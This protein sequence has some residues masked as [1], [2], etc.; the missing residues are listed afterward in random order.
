MNIKRTTTWMALIAAVLPTMALAQFSTGDEVAAKKAWEQFPNLPKSKKVTLSFRNS[1]IDM[2]LDLFM[3][4]SGITIVKDPS[5]KDAITV[6]SP[7][8]VTVADAFN[9]LDTALGLRNFEL[10]KSGNLMVIRPKRQQATID[11]GAGAAGGAGFPTPTPNEV[12]VYRIKY[13]N[14]S[15]VARVVNDVFAPQQG[16]GFGGF[17]NFNFGGGGGGGGL[18]Q[19]GRPQGQGNRGGRTNFGG[20]GGQA[21]RFTGFGGLNFGQQQSNMRASSDDFSNTVIINGPRSQFADIEKLINEIDKQTDA[22]QTSRV[23]KLEFAAAPDLVSVIQNVLTSNAPTGRGGQGNQ[24]VPPQ[25]RFQQAFRTGSFQSA[26][27]TVTADARSNSLVVTG[28]ED[29]HKVVAQVISELDQKVRL[30]DSTVVVPLMN[31]RADQV[32]TTLQQAFGQRS[33]TNTTRQNNNNTQNRNTTQNR[34]NA[35]GPPSLGGN[36]IGAGNESLSA[37]ANPNSVDLALQNPNADSGDLLTQIQFG[38]GFGGFGGGFGGGGF[39]RQQNQSQ[40]AQLVRGADG[41]LVNI[42][43]LTNQVTIIPDTNTNSLI[44]VGAPDAVELVKKILGQLDAIPEQVMIETIIMEATLDKTS[45]LGIEW[46]LVQAKAFGNTGVTGNVGTSYGLQNTTPALDG[47]RYTIAGG[48]LSG[49]MNALKQDDKFEVLSTPRIFTSNNVQA[50][51]NISQSIPYVVSQREDANGNLTFN[52]Q[53]LD[54]GII[55][56]VTPRITANGYV[57]LDVVQTANDLQGYTSFNAPIVNQR[58]A[59][60]TVSVK[61]GETMVLGGIMRSTVNSSVKKVPLLGDIPLLGELFKSTS[62]QKQKTELLVMLTPRIVRNPEDAAKLREKA[63]KENGKQ[64]PNT[65]TTPDPTPVKKDG[66][67]KKDG[68]GRK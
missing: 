57:T 46:N 7:N 33:G 53:F 35:G 36:N 58:E 68:G 41:R 44:V 51:I 66:E 60:T 15:E 20:A 49:F 3:R 32:A 6:S 52:Y 18:T 62:H 1:N 54:V 21:N 14:A 48:N 42:R 27:G 12:K 8:P 61:D 17:P 39:G 26:F 38:G 22:P 40:Q 34:N 67:A 64:L 29:N 37:N 24:S 2:V 43:D 25:Q 50:Q 4:V 47:F 63:L 59:Q 56:T 45:K 65:I 11:F 16:G 10:Q 19:F 28:T 23:Y 55:L 30:E 13:A 31:A 9:I 5:L